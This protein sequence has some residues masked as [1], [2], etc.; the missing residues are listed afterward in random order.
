MTM[1]L[2]TVESTRRLPIYTRSG[3]AIDLARRP[4]L[5]SDRTDRELKRFELASN[6]DERKVFSTI[7]LG[8]AASAFDPELRSCLDTI[9]EDNFVVT[10]VACVAA[11][12]IAVV[13]AVY[14]AVGWTAVAGVT[15]AT[16]AAVYGSPIETDMAPSSFLG[17][18]G[19]V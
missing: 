13:A 9:Q 6:A 17:F 10:P 16:W 7:G 15:A 3:A 19:A 14:V 2:E 11:A 18:E 8:A 12:Y 5:T 4:K 1:N